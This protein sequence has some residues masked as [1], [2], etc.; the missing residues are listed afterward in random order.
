MLLP[1]FVRPYVPRLSPAEWLGELTGT[2]WM[3]M[4]YA[5]SRMD[6]FEARRC[7]DVHGDV[8]GLF[9]TTDVLAVG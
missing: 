3:P 6:F 7:A 8:R 4:I 9:V 2:W 5:T 1:W